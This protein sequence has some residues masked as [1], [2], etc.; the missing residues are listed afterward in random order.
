MYY[1]LFF[2]GTSNIKYIDKN[3]NPALRFLE[4]NEGHTLLNAKINRKR[5]NHTTHRCIKK[6][7][8]LLENA[9]ETHFLYTCLFTELIEEG[10]G[11]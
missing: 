6:L 2:L 9:S 10:G 7:I 4:T 5:L 8:F 3:F 1:A 11:R